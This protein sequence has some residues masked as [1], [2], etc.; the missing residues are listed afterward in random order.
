ML[1]DGNTVIKLLVQHSIKTKGVLHVGAHKC[2]EKP[3]YNNILNIDNQNVVWIDANED[4]VKLNKA[5][6][7]LYSS[8]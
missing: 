4:L 1:I 6:G 5:K 8:T 3:F 2:E 7:I